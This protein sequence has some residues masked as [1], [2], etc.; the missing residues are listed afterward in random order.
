MSFNPFKAA[1][2]IALRIYCWDN[3]K[4]EKMYKTMVLEWNKIICCLCGEQIQVMQRWK[5]GFNAQPI[6]E[7]RCCYTC[8]TEKVIYEIIRQIK[9]GREW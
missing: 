3:E 6:K 1:L 9:E 8:K 7:G 5:F 4:G 2:M